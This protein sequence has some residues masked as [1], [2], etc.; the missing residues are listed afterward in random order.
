M[1]ERRKIFAIVL[2]I[3]GSLLLVGQITGINIDAIF[4]PL[5]LILVGL[6]LI[7][8]PQAIKM[9]GVRYAFAGDWEVDG[10]WDLNTGEVRAFAGDLTVDLRDIDLPEGETVLNFKGFAG[11][12]RVYLPQEVGLSVKTNTFVTDAR[13]E[14]DKTDYVF[15]GMD[16]ETEGYKAASKKFRLEATAFAMEID[17][18]NV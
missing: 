14:G 11:D 13:I 9:E 16:Y 5:I 3:F 17:V 1:L 8:R 15:T 2:I 7:F 18:V 12:I 6:I 10:R 4:W